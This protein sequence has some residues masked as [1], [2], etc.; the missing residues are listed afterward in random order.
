[1]RGLRGVIFVAIFFVL[2]GL[3]GYGAE[4]LCVATLPSDIVGKLVLV[5]DIGIHCLSLNYNICGIIGLIASYAVVTY[6]VKK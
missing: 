3:I 1:M 4:R 6:V 2:A 5:R